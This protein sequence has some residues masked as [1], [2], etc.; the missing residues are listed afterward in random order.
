[1]ENT[2]PVVDM[3]Q[4]TDPDDLSARQALELLYQLKEKV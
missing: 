3:L 1:V 4:H 2:H